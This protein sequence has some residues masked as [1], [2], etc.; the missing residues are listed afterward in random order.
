M[1][2]NTETTISMKN[3]STLCTLTSCRALKA[4]H[5]IICKLHTM[6]VHNLNLSEENESKYAAVLVYRAHTQLGN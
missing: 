2:M 4:V 5:N 3:I 1:D 6:F